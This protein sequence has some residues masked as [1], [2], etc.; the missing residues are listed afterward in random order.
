MTTRFTF[1][2]TL[3][4]GREA[5]YERVHRVTP[6]ALDAVIRRA[7]ARF[8]RIERNGTRLF[9][10]VE[11]DAVDSFDTVLADSAVNADWQQVVGP[12]LETE[13]AQRTIVQSFDFG[14]GDLVWELPVR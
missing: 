5:E 8:W 14:Q 10:F 2:T 11:V 9:H 6:T 4:P 1:A 12:L 13:P 7:G 3:L